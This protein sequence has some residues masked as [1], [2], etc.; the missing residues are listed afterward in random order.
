MADPILLTA[1]ISSSLTSLV[2]IAILIYL[3]VS[4]TKLGPDRFRNIII[5]SMLFFL[6][7]V[8]GVS[9]M[10]VYHLTEGSS[11]QS[12]HELTENGWYIF[13]FLSLVFSILLSLKLR[14]FAKSFNITM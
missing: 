13:M 10:T 11:L 2:G 4:V 3:I 5:L 12:L 8:V 7:V 9:T 6:V 14:S 1:Q